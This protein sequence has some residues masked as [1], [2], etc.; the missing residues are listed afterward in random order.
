M[1]KILSG[2]GKEIL[3]KSVVQAIPTYF[4]A[5]FKLP[6]GICEHITTMIRKFLWG[7]KNGERRAA[8][9]SYAE[10]NTKGV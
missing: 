5:L 4:M 6:Q 2:G 10:I 7:S 8:W 9:V 3:I 1:E